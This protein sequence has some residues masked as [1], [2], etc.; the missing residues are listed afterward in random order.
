MIRVTDI[1]EV[2]VSDNV[3]LLIE[4]DLASPEDMVKH[5]IQSASVPVGIE[6]DGMMRYPRIK[7]T[8]KQPPK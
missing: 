4:V 6:V 1:I 2:K 8:V 3:T 5:H 7:W